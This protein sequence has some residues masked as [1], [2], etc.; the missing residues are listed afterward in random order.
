MVV[1]MGGMR[2]FVKMT[3]GGYVPTYAVPVDVC[4]RRPAPAVDRQL[5]DLWPA[6]P[7]APMV[8]CWLLRAV[9]GNYAVQSMG[10]AG[11]GLHVV[12]LSP[13]GNT[14]SGGVVYGLLIC[15]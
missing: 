12:A 9:N 2:N 14:A 5:V 11:A 1:T 8:D 3:R 10:K 4:E 6:D 7:D 15:D 13:P